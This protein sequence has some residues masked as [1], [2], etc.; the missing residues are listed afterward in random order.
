MFG[1][2]N[3]V[4]D[5]AIFHTG[6]ALSAVCKFKFNLS[7][8]EDVWLIK[9]LAFILQSRLAIAQIIDKRRKLQ[10]IFREIGMLFSQALV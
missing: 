2:S 3:L 8:N 1:F 9:G 6:K 5:G 4:S 10:A 7:S